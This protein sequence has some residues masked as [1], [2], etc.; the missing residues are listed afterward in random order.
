MSACMCLWA[1]CAHGGQKAPLDTLEP[2]GS[3]QKQRAASAL[4][5]GVTIPAPILIHFVE[6]NKATDNT[7]K[8]NRGKPEVLSKSSEHLQFCCF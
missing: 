2:P 7:P 6:N 1:L 4:T 3:L 5:P 8:K